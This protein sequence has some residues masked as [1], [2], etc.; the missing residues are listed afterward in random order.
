MF[1]RLSPPAITDPQK[2]AATMQPR[3]RKGHYR[4][5]IGQQSKVPE[6]LGDRDPDTG[7][8]FPTVLAMRAAKLRDWL[9]VERRLLH[10]DRAAC[11]DFM[12]DP[13][14]VLAPAADSALQQV[15]VPG[16]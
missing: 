13:R 2:P 4:L 5:P 3:R 11:R 10:A 12:L 6:M 9:R 16:T 1:L 8:R 14:C 7:R 15:Q